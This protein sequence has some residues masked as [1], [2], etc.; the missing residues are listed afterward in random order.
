MGHEQ[1]HF[2]KVH[3]IQS[4]ISNDQISPFT[5]HT[6]V[7]GFFPYHSL[8]KEVTAGGTQLIQF[9]L[10]TFLPTPIIDINGVGIHTIEPEE[11]AMSLA[12]THTILDRLQL[13]NGKY[14]MIYDLIGGNST[15]L[16]G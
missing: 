10:R 11:M 3:D 1:D 4:G 16:D 2:Y 7:A 8:S 15:H 5:T 9:A 13:S 6:A 14:N 12:D